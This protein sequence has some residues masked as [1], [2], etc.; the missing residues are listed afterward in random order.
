MNFHK[1]LEPG[2]LLKHEHADADGDRLLVNGSQAE[3][4]S[5]LVSKLLQYCQYARQVLVLCAHKQQLH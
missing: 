3:C 1:H 5:C 2:A 4:S